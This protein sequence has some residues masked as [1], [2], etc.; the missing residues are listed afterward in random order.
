MKK[1]L[2]LSSLLLVFFAC[3]EKP[4]EKE[5]KPIQQESKVVA[6]KS[7]PTIV[8]IEKETKPIQQEPKIVAPKSTTTIVEIDTIC[9]G[10]EVE[11]KYTTFPQYPKLTAAIEADVN[12]YLNRI[13]KEIN[14][15]KGYESD[16]DYFDACML[17]IHDTI[18]RAD[19]SYIS[20]V[21][22]VSISFGSFS[23]MSLE[24]NYDVKNDKL[25]FLEDI[26]NLDSPKNVNYINACLEEYLA[27]RTVPDHDC[28]WKTMWDS[29][30]LFRKPS[31]DGI[32]GFSISEDSL[33]FYYGP[34]AF[35]YNI[36]DCT[37]VS[38]SFDALRPMMKKAL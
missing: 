17:Y 18:Y 38:V 13:K 37:C 32:D 11:V 30:D 35:G 33:H 21:M 6:P 29:D 27:D 14:E 34:R 15:R 31:L 4:A 10:C 8:E 25:L 19:D 5:T 3:S 7:T 2:I 23:L 36:Y 24:Y 16:S 28:S 26:L 20:I 9:L 12:G 22:D 1:L